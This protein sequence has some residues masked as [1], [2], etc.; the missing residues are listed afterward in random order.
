[1]L[2]LN[3]LEQKFYDAFIDERDNTDNEVCY[4]LNI[5]PQVVVGIYRVDFVVNGKYV[6]EID[7]HEFHKTKEQREHDYIRERYLVKHGFIVIRFTGTEVFLSCASC[8]VEAV[9]IID[10]LTMEAD[11]A[12]AMSCS[13]HYNFMVDR[14]REVRERGVE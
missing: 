6:I 5:V 8:A 1:V 9:K 7:G 4:E 3:E 13:R 2:D 11:Y 12:D 14:E 10:D